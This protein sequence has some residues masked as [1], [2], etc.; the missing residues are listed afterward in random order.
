MTCGRASGRHVWSCSAPAMLEVAPV[1]AWLGRAVPPPSTTQGFLAQ[2]A[3]VASTHYSRCLLH[4]RAK[5]SIPQIRVALVSVGISH[6]LRISPCECV[7][8]HIGVTLS[9][10]VKT[11][12]KTQTCEK[13]GSSYKV[14]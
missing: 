9:G 11:D 6:E 8:I 1:L 7:T 2:L 12:V 10:F 14:I 4:C 5:P 13:A 3:L